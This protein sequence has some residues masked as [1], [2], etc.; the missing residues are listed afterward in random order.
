M[1]K[2]TEHLIPL[3]CEGFSHM[4]ENQKWYLLGFCERV[5]MEPDAAQTA[6]P[7]LPG[8]R[9]GAAAVGVRVDALL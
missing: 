5:S 7:E 1:T 4:T 9:P 2:T 8:K 3:I 6:R